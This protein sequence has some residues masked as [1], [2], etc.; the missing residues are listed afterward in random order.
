MASLAASVTWFAPI[1][2]PSK[3]LKLGDRAGGAF[4]GLRCFCGAGENL[5]DAINPVEVLG[6]HED[7]AKA[8]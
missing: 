2:E 5:P 4:E 6:L 3:F 1:I 7:G 8:G